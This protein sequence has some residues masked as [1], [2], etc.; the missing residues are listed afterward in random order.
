MVVGLRKTPEV[1]RRR[2]VCHCVSREA[3]ERWVLGLLPL[4]SRSEGLVF[5]Y[6]LHA[7]ACSPEVVTS[8]S[9]LSVTHRNVSRNLE[10]KLRWKG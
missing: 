2:L 9:R 5:S 6:T 8:L 10:C 1:T 4:L 3:C 7:S